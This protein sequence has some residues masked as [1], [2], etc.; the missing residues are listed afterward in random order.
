MVSRIYSRAIV[1][2]CHAAFRVYENSG[3]VVAEAKHRHRL[4]LVPL[5]VP[6]RSV[7]PCVHSDFL[8][9]SEKDTSDERI[10]DPWSSYTGSWGGLT[11][12]TSDVSGPLETS[13]CPGLEATPR[14]K[15]CQE[16]IKR[17]KT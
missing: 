9:S 13:V 7:V 8:S 17:F 5:L 11:R 14:C 6:R 2:E 15:R 10:G 16:M 1:G 3:I 12:S 4:V